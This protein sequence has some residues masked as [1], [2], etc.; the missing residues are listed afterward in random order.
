MPALFIWA[1]SAYMYY[2]PQTSSNPSFSS[3]LEIS[4]I[5]ARSPRALRANVERIADHLDL[6]HL[7]KISAICVSDPEL[8]APPAMGGG[9][10]EEE[11]MEESGSNLSLSQMP[12]ELGTSAYK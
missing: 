5:S 10:T 11:E 9:E 7:R 6:E 4:L 3:Q 8:M 2:P 1:Y 12:S